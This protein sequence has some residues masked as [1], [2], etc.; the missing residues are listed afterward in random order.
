MD[1]P[2]RELSSGGLESVVV[3]LVHWEI[4]FLSAQTLTLNPAVGKRCGAMAK[5]EKRKEGLEEMSHTYSSFSLKKEVSPYYLLHRDITHMTM[6]LHIYKP[7][8][9]CVF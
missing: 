2:R 8:Q 4:V 7:T 9:D 1:A 5:R 6:C 3:L